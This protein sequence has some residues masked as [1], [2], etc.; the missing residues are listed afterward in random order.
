MRRAAATLATALLGLALAAPAALAK[1]DHG[2]GLWGETDDK[3]VT[4]A[5]FIIIAAFPLL[6]LILSLLQRALDKRKEAH[7]AAM[8]RRAARPTSGW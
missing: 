1:S 6:I 2:E 4:N 5:G 8:K 3:I 7:K